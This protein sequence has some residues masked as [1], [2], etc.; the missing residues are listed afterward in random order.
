MDSVEQQQEDEWEAIQ[1]IYPDI[2]QDLT[3]KKS[4]WNKKPPHKFNLH[5]SS[6]TSDDKIC[7][8]DLQV[9]FTATYPLSPPLYRFTNVQ[10]IM[11]SQLATIKEKCKQLL[12][13]YKGQPIVFILYSE[14]FDYL[15]EIKSSIKNESL[16]EERKR[17]ILNEQLELEKIEQQE[18]E[19]LEIKREKEQELLDEMVEMEMKRRYQSSNDNFQEFMES[20]TDNKTSSDQDTSVHQSLNRNNSASTEDNFTSDSNSDVNY[21]FFDKPI[22]VQLSWINFKFRAITGFVPIEQIGRAHV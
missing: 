16:E 4:A 18:Q 2:L 5:V 9:E 14:I 7:S 6:D 1:A 17:R 13:E 20:Y 10:N 22:H 15:N 8:L 11:D 21:F 19:Q 3:P 12:K